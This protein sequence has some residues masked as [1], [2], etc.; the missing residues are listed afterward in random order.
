MLT[1]QPLGTP[2]A[3]W[4]ASTVGRW[5]PAPP[6]IP[7]SVV[8]AAPHPD[9]EVL[10]LGM[11]L[12]GLEREGCQVTILACTDGEASHARSDLITPDQLVVR[13]QVERALALHRLGVDPVVRRLQLPDSG[14][15]RHTAELTR[16][17]TDHA[18]DGATLVVP[19]IHDDHPDHRAVAQAGIRAA[20]RSGAPLWQV[21]IWGKVRRVHG[22]TGRVAH[23]HLTAE[24]IAWKAEAVRAFTSQLEPLGPGAHDGPVVHPDELARMLDGT[25]TVLW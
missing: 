9:D 15:S 23:L 7:E 10:G 11:V 5:T 21:P 16:H 6:P 4:E 2:S 22:F 18:A 3:R 14:L 25:E 13:R 19:W 24:A 12:V 20:R 8:V 17:L 1:Q